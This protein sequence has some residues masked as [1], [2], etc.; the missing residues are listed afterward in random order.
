MEQ[1]HLIYRDLWNTGK[2]DALLFLCDLEASRYRQ[3]PFF[4]WGNLEATIRT[5]QVSAR[6]TD[7]DTAGSRRSWILSHSRSARSNRRL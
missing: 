1:L 3:A 7:S 5:A 6:F 4:L 2:V